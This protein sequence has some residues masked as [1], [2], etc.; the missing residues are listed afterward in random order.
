MASPMYTVHW[1]H[2]DLIQILRRPCLSSTP[3]IVRLLQ[4]QQYVKVEK[5]HYFLPVICHKQTGSWN[6]QEQGTGSD[7]M[8]SLMVKLNILTRTLAVI[9]DHNAARNHTYGATSSQGQNML[10]TPCS[11]L[12]QASPPFNVCWVC[13][14]LWSRDPM[15]VP[16]LDD[17]WPTYIFSWIFGTRACRLTAVD[18]LTHTTNLVRQH[19]S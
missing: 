2:P 1:Q 3:D 11:T 16:A 15:D 14:F 4:H 9:S 5:C 13:P 7:R 18:N 8:A 19:C 10:K 6:A 12:S 17:L